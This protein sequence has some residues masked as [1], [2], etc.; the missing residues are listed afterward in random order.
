MDLTGHALLLENTSKAAPWEQLILNNISK[1]GD[2]VNVWNNFIHIIFVH[3]LKYN[4]KIG[5]RQLVGML[6]CV[7]VKKEHMKNITEVKLNGIG[8]GL[9][10]KMVKIITKNCLEKN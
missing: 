9:M 4:S 3:L 7:F 2:Y 10:G 1:L 6:I 8:C 5:S